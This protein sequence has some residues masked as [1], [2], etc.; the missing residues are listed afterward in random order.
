MNTNIDVYV[1]IMSKG[2]LGVLW[3]MG[4]IIDRIREE[5]IIKLLFFFHALKVFARIVVFFQ[6]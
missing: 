3:N 5:I 6:I 2:T 4:Q 1:Y